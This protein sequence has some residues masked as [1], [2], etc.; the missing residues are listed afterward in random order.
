MKNI[1]T[2]IQL[3][4]FFF[5]STQSLRATT[6][7]VDASRP[8]NTGAGTSWATAKKDVQDAINLASAG[9]QVWVK[10][11]TYTPTQYP[12]G[13]SGCSIARNY[14]FFVKDGVKL[15]G[16][17]AGAETS[18]AQRNIAANTTTLSGEIGNLTDATDNS[19]HVVM[20]VAPSTGGIGVMLDGFTIQDGQAKGPIVS[21]Q[22]GDVTISNKYGGGIFIQGGANTIS[23]NTITRNLANSQGG[24]IYISRATNTITTNTIFDND[25]LTNGGGGIHIEYGASD[26]YDNT[27]YDNAGYRGGGIYLT[28][29]TFVIRHNTLYGNI[30]TDAGG[31]LLLT[32][33]SNSTIA[34]NVL[35]K[36]K[37]AQAGG[38]YYIWGYDTNQ[39]LNNTIVGNEATSF[40]G[41]GIYVGSSGTITIKN[42]IFWGNK[43]GSNSN[44]IGGTPNTVSHCLTQAG[45]PF[46]TGVGII[47]NQ[48]PLFVD[49][50]DID[51]P[52]NI[53]RTADD[54][55]NLQYLSPCVD[56]GIMDV[57]IPTTDILEI[58]RPQYGIPDIGAYEQSA[59]CLNGLRVYVDAA[60]PDNSGDGLSWATAKKDIQAAINTANMC[61]Q[62]WV[63]AGTYK[64]TQEPDGTTDTPRDFT[65]YI[66]GSVG[67]YGGFAGTETSLS[68]RNI[69]AN[70]TTLSGD[71]GVPNNNTDNAYHVVVV[72]SLGNSTQATVDGFHIT[73]GNANDASNLVLNG[74]NIPRGNGGG[75]CILNGTNIIRNNT[76][77]NNSCSRLGGGI[78]ALSGVHTIKQN[79][80][81]NNI[82]STRGGGIYSENATVTI[83]N[84]TMQGNTASVRGGGIYAKSGTSTITNNTIIHNTGSLR[85]GGIYTEATVSTLG[86]NVLKSNTAEYGGGVY[87]EVGTNTILNNTIVQNTSSVKGGGLYTY[88][89]SNVVKNCL[90]WNNVM[91]TATNVLGADLAEYVSSNTVTYCLTQQNSLYSNGMGIINNQDPLFANIAD[92]DGVDNTHR[93]ADDGLMLSCATPVWNQQVLDVGLNTDILGVA[94]PQQVG[95]RYG[96]YESL[97]GGCSF[98][99]DA[100]RPDNTGA[101]TSWATAKKD[102]QDAINLALAGDQVWVRAGTYKPTQYPVGCTGCADARDYTFFIK[103]GVKLYGGFCRH[104]KQPYPAQYSS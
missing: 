28:F 14:T 26:I 42:N 6:Y 67:I 65:F 88:Q 52:D 27:I 5:A 3:F 17:F 91:G 9:D 90:F 77:D 80:I 54:G 22:I 87:T 63:K 41:G 71:V 101:G 59:E 92:I 10:A 46:S 51:G 12:A 29:G 39:I 19:Y 104:R 66:Q 94:R 58:T 38:L 32:D 102:V 45:S 49:I 16:G 36:N 11:G 23:N 70:I 47:N 15:Y 61:G 62:V 82:A 81:S 86:N 74:T 50:N 73:G 76:L 84:N 56:E 75:I 34:N 99:V 8:D 69:T 103:D 1:V 60:R 18:L 93:T 53:H 96:A 2:L 57:G 72:N 30:A 20:A 95:V 79:E 98:Y 89:G 24:G 7:Y 68:Q 55:L 13:C 85:G 4:L 25:V 64:P 83:H 21:I 43:V 48:D 37:A 97:V 35:Y 78:Y 31:G 100:S 33:V 40:S 44:D